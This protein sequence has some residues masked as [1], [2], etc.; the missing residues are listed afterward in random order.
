MAAVCGGGGRNRERR[1][2]VRRGHGHRAGRPPASGA[3]LAAAVEVMVPSEALFLERRRAF[4]QTGSELPPSLKLRRTGRMAGHPFLISLFYT[5]ILESVANPGEFYR[6]HTDDRKRRLSEHNAGKCSHTSKSK[7]WKVK[8][9]AA[10]DTIELTREFETYLK[11]G[12]GHAFAKRHFGLTPP[13]GRQSS[14]KGSR[15]ASMLSRKVDG[16]G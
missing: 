1:N 16:F 12:S 3:A 2:T 4:L 6:G 15:E 10:F 11:S 14:G 7:P 5:Y 8:F 9:Y 13:V